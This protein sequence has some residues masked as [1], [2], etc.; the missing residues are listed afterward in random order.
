MESLESFPYEIINSNL[1]FFSI[2]LNFEGAE[3][4]VNLL[5]RFDAS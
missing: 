4:S 1:S 3:E 2:I 5:Y